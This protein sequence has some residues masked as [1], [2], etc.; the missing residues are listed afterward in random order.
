SDLKPLSSWQIPLQQRLTNDADFAGTP[1]LFTATRSN[2]LVQKL[3]GAVDKNGYF[4]AFDRSNL[5]APTN[6]V[7]STQIS[8]EPGSCPQCG[9]GSISSAVW[10][11]GKNLYVAGGNTTFTD[12]QTCG[13]SLQDL[14][15]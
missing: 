5:A 2:G 12:G 8:T 13:G 7:W 4:Y 11:G 9:K 15:P 1:T 10:D 14:D 6:P 3:V